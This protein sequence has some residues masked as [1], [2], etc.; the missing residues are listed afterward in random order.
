MTDQ[1][2]CTVDAKRHELIVARQRLM[3][4]LEQIDRDLA[5]L[6]QALD[7]AA[8]PFAYGIT[9]GEDVGE[10][11]LVP[12]DVDHGVPV[13]YRPRT[14]LDV[15]TEMARANGGTVHLTTAAKQIISDGLSEATIPAH[16]TATLHAR[17]KRDPQWQ[18]IGR[19]LFQLVADQ[20]QNPPSGVEP[21][22]GASADEGN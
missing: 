1:T 2:G 10:L 17:M 12:G 9:P 22:A 19:G 4:T 15:V 20:D 3:T 5:I 11:G 21:R 7:V 14:H 13:A 16:I 8:R 6:E 18:Q